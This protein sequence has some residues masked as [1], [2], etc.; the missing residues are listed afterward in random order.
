MI[1]AEMTT[2]PLP[3]RSSHS[4]MMTATAY[5][6]SW[7]RLRKSCSRISS[8][9]RNLSLRSVSISGPYSGGPAGSSD[10]S[11][12]TRLS[13]L[14]PLVADTGTMAR[15]DSFLFSRSSTGSSSVF[16]FSVSTLLTASTTGRRASTSSRRIASSGLPSP[17]LALPPTCMATSTSITSSAA[18]MSGITPIASST[19]KRLSPFFAPC[20]PGVSTK[21]IWPRSWL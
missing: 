18:S 7:R 21:T 6:I 1:V 12:P 8:P 14:V 19:M 16:A 15:S 4:S 2:S 13:T 5:G 3:S 11:S 17:P 9:A 20:T 10:H